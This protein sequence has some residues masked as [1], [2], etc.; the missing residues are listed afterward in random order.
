MMGSKLLL[1]ELSDK[2]RLILELR[3]QLERL[4]HGLAMPYDEDAVAHTKRLIAEAEAM[5]EDHPGIRLACMIEE[6]R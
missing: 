6:R 1:Q 2:E 5:P 4:E 3:I